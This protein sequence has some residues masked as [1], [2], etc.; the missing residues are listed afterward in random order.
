MKKVVS[1]MIICCILMSGCIS[2]RPAEYAAYRE[3]EELGVRSGDHKIKDPGLAAALNILPGF[4]NFYL[5]IG[6][7]YPIQWGSGLLNLLL[8]PY[9]IIWGVPEAAIEATTINK[10]EAL[11]YYQHNP[12]GIQKLKALKHARDIRIKEEE[13][14]I[15][16]EIEVIEE[17]EEI[18]SIDN[19]PL[20]TLNI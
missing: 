1:L 3:L 9:S 7:D 10:K 18:P 20:E 17:T 12:Y 5:A 2:M 8:W 6:T 4:G 13:P 19:T 14:K 15:E 16:A 11:Y